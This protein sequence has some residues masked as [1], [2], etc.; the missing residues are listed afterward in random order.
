MNRCALSI[1]ALLVVLLVADA[2]FAPPFGLLQ[3]SIEK[4]AEGAGDTLFDFE[5]DFGSFSLGH[6]DTYGG[7][8]PWMLAPGDYDIVEMS[9]P[10]WLLSEIQVIGVP[11]DLI[12]NGVTLHIALDDDYAGVRFVN[13]RVP[14]VPAPGAIL[15]GMIGSGMV[16]WMRRHRTL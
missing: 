3:L 11:Y 9:T 12:A 16:G 4:I 13:E 14:V 15:L 7:N 10:G 6:G 2:C 1:S 5:S 8:V